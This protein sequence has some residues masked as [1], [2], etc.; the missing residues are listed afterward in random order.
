VAK[1]EGAKKD[2]TPKGPFGFGRPISVKGI[3][4]FIGLLLINLW[5]DFP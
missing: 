4:G 3:K 5:L 1:V 2:D